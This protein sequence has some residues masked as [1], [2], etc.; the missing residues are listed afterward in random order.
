MLLLAGSA[1][2]LVPPKNPRNLAA[3]LK[4]A[5]KPVDVKFYPGARHLDM[6][7]AFSKPGQQGFRRARRYGR[8]DVVALSFGEK[9]LLHRYF[10]S[11]PICGRSSKP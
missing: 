9:P 11:G 1:E 2:T 10:T 3:A 4:K 6:L 5:H 7:F 8:L